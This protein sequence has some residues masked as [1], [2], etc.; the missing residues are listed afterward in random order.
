M[1]TL[2]TLLPEHVLHTPWFTVLASF[3][4]LNTLM[5]CALSLAKVLPKVYLSDWITS[6]NR[7]AQTRSI[8]PEGYV[9]P[10]EDEVLDPVA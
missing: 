1:T 9:A 6:T 10:D 8:Y 4:A 5:Y 2:T 3:V 7:R